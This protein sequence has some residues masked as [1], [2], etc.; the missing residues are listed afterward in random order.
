MSGRKFGKDGSTEEVVHRPCVG[1]TNHL[2][3][4]ITL[5]NKIKKTL[6][7]NYRW[8]GLL[9]W[10]T[11]L[12]FYAIKILN[13]YGLYWWYMQYKE[14]SNMASCLHIL[15]MKIILQ[16]EQYNQ[17]NDCQHSY[18]VDT[19]K[20]LTWSLDMIAHKLV[21]LWLIAQLLLGRVIMLTACRYH[22]RICFTL[23]DRWI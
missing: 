15:T 19:D 13:F 17:F 2:K 3:W 11:G 1:V 18:R 10:T 20:C 9:E 8:T 14:A 16:Q 21:K 5:L 6:P 23:N 4:S 7:V 22:S 12:T